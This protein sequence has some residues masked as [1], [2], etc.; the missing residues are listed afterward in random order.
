M[1]IFMDNTCSLSDF[2][3]IITSRAK[4]DCIKSG[5]F[6]EACKLKTPKTLATLLFSCTFEK[7]FELTE[8]LKI[9]LPEK[10]RKYGNAALSGKGN[11]FQELQDPGVT[12]SSPKLNILTRMNDKVERIL[13]GAA[14]DDEDP[15]MDLI[16]YYWLLLYA[17]YLNAVKNKVVQEGDLIDF[18]KER[19]FELWKVS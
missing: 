6:V 7:S 12:I 18:L 16:G 11:F 13:A 15:V 5:D 17:E 10:N 1:V 14:D 19:R 9:I 2:L 8:K 3:K 4:P